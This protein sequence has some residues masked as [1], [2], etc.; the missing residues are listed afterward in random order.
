MLVLPLH[1]H[2]LSKNLHFYFFPQEYME[3]FEKCAAGIWDTAPP[4]AAG[5]K[6]PTHAIVYGFPI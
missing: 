3:N 6:I 1:I 2:A 4:G 5:V